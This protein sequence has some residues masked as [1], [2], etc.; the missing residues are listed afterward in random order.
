MATLTATLRA[1]ICATPAQQ[2]LGLAGKADLGDDDCYVFPFDPPRV[3]VMSTDGMLFSLDIVMIGPDGLVSEIHRAVPPDDRVVS[4]GLVSI[5]LELAA[6]GADFFN[7]RIGQKLAA[8]G[9][10]DA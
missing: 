1:A 3:A 5:V 10:F 6:G 9:A 2:R 4:Q 8:L 7:M